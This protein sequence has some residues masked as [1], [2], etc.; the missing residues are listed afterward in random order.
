MPSARGCLGPP[1]DAVRRCSAPNCPVLVGRLLLVVL[2]GTLDRR[3]PALAPLHPDLLFGLQLERSVI[4]TSQPNLDM[5][6]P[7]GV[8]DP[9]ATAGTEAATV[10]ARDVAAHLKRI[11][12]PPRVHRERAARLLPTTRAVATDDVQGLTANGVADCPAETSAGTYSGFHAPMLRTRGPAY[13]SP[14]NVSE[15]G[16]NADDELT[17]GPSGTPS[18]PAESRRARWG[19][20][21]CHPAA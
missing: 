8:E 14:R 9:R 11:D 3:Y 18:K 17:I 12:G 16:A 21:R 6:A 19:A 4:E 15:S 1:G 5:H 13:I 2:L 10:I 7:G 20:T